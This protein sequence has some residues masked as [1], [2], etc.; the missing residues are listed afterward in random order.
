MNSVLFDL[1]VSFGVLSLIALFCVYISRPFFESK[2]ARI[3]SQAIASLLLLLSFGLSKA[4]QDS[5]AA[6]TDEFIVVFLVFL[7]IKAVAMYLI[8]CYAKSVGKSPYWS[9]IGLTNA[10]IAL[11]FMAISLWRDPKTINQLPIDE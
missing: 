10:G 8:G 5:S 4:M 11:C 3:V 6:S 1:A 9:F 2:V 7:S